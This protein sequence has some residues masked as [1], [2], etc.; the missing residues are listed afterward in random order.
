MAL[1]VPAGRR[2][3]NLILGLVGALVV[4]IVLGVVVGRVTAPTLS[5]KVSSVQ[6]SVRGVTARIRATPL[7]YQKQLSG[8]TQFQ[9]G[10]TVAQSLTDAR[11]SLTAALDDAVWLGTAQRKELEDSMAALLAVAGS[12]TSSAR[13]GKLAEQTAVGIETSFGIDR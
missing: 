11:R 6:D 7:E 5:D 4:G 3:R 10:G 9:S 8:S 12:K 1:Y 2:R 13:Y